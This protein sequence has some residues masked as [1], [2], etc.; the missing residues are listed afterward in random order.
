MTVLAAKSTS[1]FAFA[2]SV[3]NALH[4][5]SAAAAGHAIHFQLCV[6]IQLE[7]TF[8]S[9]GDYL[10]FSLR[11]DKTMKRTIEPNMIDRSA[12]LPSGEGA[13]SPPNDQGRNSPAVANAGSP[14]PHMVGGSTVGGQ[15]PLP[16]E[17]LASVTGQS[18]SSVASRAGFGGM[19]VGPMSN[20][21]LM[22]RTPSE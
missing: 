2:S 5:G 1:T 11:A 16:V 8:G 14:V 18:P 6:A 4:T 17:G 10:F 15:T 20:P 22:V 9:L 13:D 3:C 12:A 21:Q 19:L 7:G